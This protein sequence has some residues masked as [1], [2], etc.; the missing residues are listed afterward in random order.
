METKNLSVPFFL[1]T[2]SH[3][4][5]TPLNGVV[6]YTQ[7]LFQTK[8]STDQ[9]MYL[10]ALNKCSLQLISLLNDIIDYSKLSIGKMPIRNECFSIDE[11]VSVVKSATSERIREKRQN[12]R[13]TISRNL[14]KFIVADK[15]KLIQVLVNL[16]SNAN[17][18]TDIKGF[19]SIHISPKQKGVLEFTVKDTG[20]G[21]SKDDQEKL[22]DAFFQVEKSIGQTGSGL[23]LAI[24]YRLV[25]ILGG[26]LNVT[27]TLKQGTTF[28]FTINYQESKQYH[29]KIEKK[30]GNLKD[31]Y[32]LVVDDNLDSR[33]T[34]G[35]SLFDWGMKP[36]VCS[37]SIE[38][39]QLIKKKRY[40]FSLA[41]LDI[42]MPGLSGVELARRIKLENPT[43]PLIGVSSMEET[44]DT[45]FERIIKKPINFTQLLSMIQKIFKGSLRASIVID[46][47]KDNKEDKNKKAI[48]PKNKI[49]MVDDNNY[50]LNLLQ[51]M[52]EVLNYKNVSR[53]HNYDTAIEALKKSPS[54]VFLDL[55]MKG[56]NGF[57]IFEYISKK[58]LSCKTV[59]L[60]ASVM[61]KDKE[62]CKNMGVKYF[63]SK[64]YSI[65]QIKEALIY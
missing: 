57:D 18:F 9:K 44:D 46:N 32:V 21:I 43:L 2:L 13:Y 11:V 59:V 56:K 33:I 42:C 60:T 63:I 61:D 54:L 40:S 15:Q 51:N 55:K 48:D 39:E 3:E 31:K 16:V 30:I 4:I 14:P 24:S 50:N 26:T 53:A 41:I 12:C 64:P 25:K 10:L 7:L 6:G 62:R 36:I 20:V 58:N 29:Q 23:G 38:A 35:E 45:D 17:K 8:L 19:I 1:S 49:L 22:F 34:L 65:D 28:S 47:K 52:L 37:S 27:S 5:R